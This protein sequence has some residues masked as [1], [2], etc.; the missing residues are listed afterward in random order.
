[1]SGPAQYT[2]GHIPRNSILSFYLP[3]RTKFKVG[4]KGAVN[5]RHLYSC[6]SQAL[7]LAF[8]AAP[9]FHAFFFLFLNEKREGC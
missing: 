2:F 1:M 9:F 7:K 4:K 6:V 3:K 8:F 5:I